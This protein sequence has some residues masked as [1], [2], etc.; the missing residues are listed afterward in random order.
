VFRAGAM[1][2]IYG[3]LYKIKGNS[4]E[5]VQ[6]STLGALGSLVGCTGSH[7]QSQNP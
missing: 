5:K 2:R 4:A 1:A 3:L 6:K 7:V